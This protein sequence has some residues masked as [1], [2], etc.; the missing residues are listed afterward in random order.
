MKAVKQASDYLLR[1]LEILV[2]LGMLAIATTVV[3]QVL[4]NALFEISKGT[5]FVVLVF[6]DVELPIQVLD[7]HVRTMFGVSVIRI[8]F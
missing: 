4:V 7:T 1:L 2:A 8:V 6:V 3:A 5:N